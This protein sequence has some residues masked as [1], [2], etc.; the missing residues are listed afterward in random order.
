MFI[1]H[2]FCVAPRLP[3]FT[4][5]RLRLHPLLKARTV[6]QPTRHASNSAFRSSSGA[7][8]ARRAV[9]AAA[10][11]VT[12]TLFAAYY[13]DS[14]SAL[15]RYIVTPAMRYAMDPEMSHKLAVKV[16][17]SGWAPRDV[18][19]DDKRIRTTV[20]QTNTSSLSTCSEMARTAMGR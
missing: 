20:C 12:G 19:E 3:M 4:R 7:T 1:S 17:R 9:A 10:F 2:T 16:L 15:H 18:C 14:R 5:F 11:T 13:F 8:V 6:V